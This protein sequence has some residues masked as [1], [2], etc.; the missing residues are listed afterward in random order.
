MHKIWITAFIDHGALEYAVL[1]YVV[2]D[3]G[4]CQRLK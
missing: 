4:W 2:H 3:T 1:Q